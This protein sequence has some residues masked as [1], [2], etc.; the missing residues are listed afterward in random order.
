[1]EFIIRNY[2]EQCGEVLRVGYGN[3]KPIALAAVTANP[4]CFI[5]VSLQLRRD[6]DV[7][8]AAHRDPE[9][10]SDLLKQRL[11]LSDSHPD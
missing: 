11:A 2:P 6:P 5:D 10:P 8:K 3:Y 4:D 7:C 9:D 1:M